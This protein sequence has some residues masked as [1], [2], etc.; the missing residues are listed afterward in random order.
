MKVP[1]RIAGAASLLPGRAVDTV[2]LVRASMPGRDAEALARRIGI[3]S[4]HFAVAEE[5]VASVGAAVLTRALAAAGLAPEALRRV[6]LVNSHAGDHPIPAT[7]NALLETMGLHDTVGGFDLNN[8]CTG[9]VSGF[10]AAARMV[11]TGEGPV[12]VVAVEL[13]S[14]FIGPSQPR[15]YVVLGDAAAAVVLTEA[16]GPGALLAADFGNDGR[17]LPT[18]TLAHPGLTGQDEKIVFGAPGPDFAQYAIDGLVTSVRRVLDRAALTPTE[19]DWWAFHQPN[20]ELLDAFLD[21]LALDP[22]RTVRVVD[23]IGSV[24]AAS[25]AYTLERLLATRPVRTGDR[26]ILCGVGAGASRGAVLMQVERSDGT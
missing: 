14:R 9:F 21:R 5:S 24:G 12:A 19:V 20:G 7:V 23:Q 18:V 1:F 16:Q 26:L 4:R 15:S 6:I 13:L 11:A 25:A 2:S 8:A 17:K 22:A 3:E 10:D